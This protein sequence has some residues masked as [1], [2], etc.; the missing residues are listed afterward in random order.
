[1]DWKQGK[2]ILRGG[3]AKQKSYE[4]SAGV[5]TLKPTPGGRYEVFRGEERIALGM[6]MKAAKEYAYSDAMSLPNVP[7]VSG[8]DPIQDAGHPAPTSAVHDDN[9]TNN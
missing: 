4:W 1:M 3:R 7:G 5:Y 6:S 9:G 2:T 8:H